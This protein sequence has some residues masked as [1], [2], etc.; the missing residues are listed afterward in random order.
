[1]KTSKNYWKVFVAL[2]ICILYN[3]FA[4]NFQKDNKLLYIIIVGI[5]GLLWG[6][7]MAQSYV[8]GRREEEI[9]E[10]GI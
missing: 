5:S 8:W 10:V 9:S 7:F 6:W 2:V 4:Y 3:V 1:M